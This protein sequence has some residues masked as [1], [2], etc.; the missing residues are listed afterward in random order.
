MMP[1]AKLAPPPAPDEAGFAEVAGLIAAALQ[2]AFQA[3]RTLL[4][5]GRVHQPEDRSRKV[6]RGR[7]VKT[8]S[9]HSKK[10]AA[11]GA[12]LGG[13]CPGDVWKFYETYREAP[14]VAALLRQL[15]WTHNITILEQSKRPEEREFYPPH[16]D[17]GIVVK[18]R[19]GA[20][21]SGCPVR[22]HRSLVGKS[23]TSGATNVSRASEHL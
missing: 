7:G 6:G 18:P 13:L 20:T 22:A 5:G 19:A 23:R 8:G 17:T 12:A 10:I 15:P 1:K 3:H 11:S 4:V 2:R 9:V 16:G 14:I 21:I